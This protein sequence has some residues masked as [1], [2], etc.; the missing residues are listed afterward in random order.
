MQ[1]LSLQLYTMQIDTKEIKCASE[2]YVID[3]KE[4]PVKIIKK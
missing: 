4:Q 2:I 1:F 3:S